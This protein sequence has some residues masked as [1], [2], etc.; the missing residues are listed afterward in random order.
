MNH[1]KEPLRSLWVGPYRFES[2]FRAL[3][4]YTMTNYVDTFAPLLAVSM[5]R[6]DFLQAS[7]TNKPSV[8]CYFEIP[9][10][11]ASYK[12]GL[13]AGRFLGCGLRLQ[14]SQSS[15]GSP[16]FGFKYSVWA[17]GALQMLPA[18]TAG[19]YHIQD[20]PIGP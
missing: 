18:F 14:A 19:S 17:K 1:K 7:F 12:F 10:L 8:P 4:R 15:I 9:G 11:P 2:G 5:P 13:E 16:G 6:H 20:L 3:Y